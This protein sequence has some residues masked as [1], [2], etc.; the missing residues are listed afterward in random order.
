MRT[1]RRCWTKP[2][3]PFLPIEAARPTV[4]DTHSHSDWIWLQVHVPL[5]TYQVTGN[6]ALPHKHIHDASWPLWEFPYVVMI[7]TPKPGSEPRLSKGNSIWRTD[8][9]NLVSCSTVY[10]LLGMDILVTVFSWVLSRLIRWVHPVCV[11]RG[12]VSWVVTH[13]CH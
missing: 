10:E 4:L 9:Q 13:F 8:F 12:I 3:P 6:V 7:S 2:F 1:G 11:R 5:P